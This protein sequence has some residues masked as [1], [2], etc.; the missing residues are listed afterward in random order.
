[1]GVS[2]QPTLR[3]GD[4]VLRP[5]R[6]EDIESARLG[7][8][9]E[10]ALWLGLSATAPSPE[11]LQRE[12]ADRR[13]AYADDR[14]A[15]SFVVER[16]GR[17]AGTVEVRVVDGTGHVSWALYAGHRGRGTAT[18]GLRLLI[19]YSFEVLGLHRVQ[20]YVAQDNHRSLRVASR[21]GLR[22]EGLLRGRELRHGVR[23]DDVLMARLADDPD[24]Q[25]RDGFIA[26]LNAGLPTKRVICQGVLRD[27][28]HRILL[29]ELTYKREWDLPGGVVERHESPATGLERELTE[30]LGVDL[31]PVELVTVNWLPA[32]RG[33]D[34]ACVFVFDVG[35]VDAALV[36]TMVLQPTE[37]RAV[38]WC[39]AAQVAEHAAAATARL[40]GRLENGTSVSPY[41][42]DAEDT[43]SSERS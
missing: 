1:M 28:D 17:I 39:T 13:R 7:H 15:V 25:S 5:W 21:A 33:W 6:D 12:L 14:R 37:I 11:Q 4:V 2:E 8:D 26:M 38:H 35:V 27:R 30:E 31:V 24:A 29:C 34:D 9:E 42:E 36:E 20:A 43:T 32:W 16:D 22:R 40:L 3:D 41:L 19:A 18:R 23:S 10:I